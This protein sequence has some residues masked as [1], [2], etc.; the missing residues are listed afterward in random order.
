MSLGKYDNNAISSLKNEETVRLRPSVIFGTNDEFGAFR[1]I[2]EI[3]ANSIDEVREGYGENIKV[4]L[5]Q[6]GSIEVSDNGRGVP[7]DWNEREDK[8]NWE[9]VFCTLYASGKYG[10]SVYGDSLGL[11]GLGATAMQYASEYMDVYSTRDGKCY[12]MH[13]KKGK[14]VGK[15]V[16]RDEK[17][18]NISGTRI[19]FKPDSEVFINIKNNNVPLEMYIDAFRRITML[20]KALEIKVYHE[21]TDKE[22]VLNY[23][24]GIIEFIDSIQCKLIL[25]ESIEFAGEV[26]G[27]DD[28]DK[29]PTPYKLK[30]R[31]VLNF[32]R[33]KSFIEM[34]HNT[35]YLSEGGVTMDSLRIG[36]TRAFED[37]AK[38]SGKLAK[39]EKILF[40]DIEAIL[41]AIGDTNAPGNR[42]FFK[43]QT[44]AA[45]NNPFIRD[46]FAKFVYANVRYWLTKGSGSDLIIDEVLLNK[47]AREEAEKV[48]KRVVQSLSK[49]I[50]GFLNKPKKFV[51]C[52]SNI[53]GERELYIVEGDSALGSCKLSRDSKFQAIMPIRGKIMNCLKEE[54]PQILQ[55]EVIID[56]LRV[57]GCGI[58]VESKTIENLPKFDL[59]KLN[60]GKVII[61]TDADLDGMQIR[62]LI[63]SMLYRI[64]PTVIKSNKVYIAETPLFEINYKNETK[65]AYNQPEKD[66]IISKYIKA[67]VKEEQIKVQR[68]KGLGENDPE[69]MSVSTMSPS[70]RRLVPVEFKGEDEAV[71][72]CFHS[73]LGDDI[74]SRRRIIREF[75]DKTVVDLE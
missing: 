22:I 12:E 31:L 34:Y 72:K 44:K 69:M 1:G 52:Q 29:D 20:T 43:N 68:S 53:V 74:E 60:W 19:K 40:K 33:E 65:F 71:H 21:E 42:T 28:I 16:I 7:M 50:S 73:L 51:D 5:F 46:E 67:G 58:E 27:T 6:D 55:N 17:D 18:K 39:N 54:L 41:I 4:S 9:L 37:C 10:G 23:E 13:F 3:I 75:F 35:S 56:L 8:F 70:T 49:S 14:P 24:G 48:S 38:E 59:S 63:L 30:M 64:V 45:I 36:L 57:L 32:S 47:R 61:C 62:C 66:S 11:N 26:S 15:L 2:L 25:P